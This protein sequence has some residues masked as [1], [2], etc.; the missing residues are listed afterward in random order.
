MKIPLSE[1]IRD[2]RYEKVKEKK[3]KIL[4]IERVG[5]KGGEKF[6]F[7]AF[8]WLATTPWAWRLLMWNVRVFGSFA[9]P[10]ASII[11]GLKQ[12][13]SCRAFPEFDASFQSEVKNM[14][15]VIYE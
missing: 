1:M 15:G 10:F 9:K 6:S 8:A 13:T 12:W 14:Q 3:E 11:P 5:A 2:L 7:G 4:G